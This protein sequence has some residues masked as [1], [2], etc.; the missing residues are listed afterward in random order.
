MLCGI[1]LGPKLDAVRGISLHLCWF[2]AR[3]ECSPSAASVSKKTIGEDP[4]RIIPVEFHSHMDHF[5][6]DA[7]HRLYLKVRTFPLVM[8]CRTSPPHVRFADLSGTGQRM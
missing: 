8:R 7:G 4:A 5:V 6:G 2:C 3:G 1:V